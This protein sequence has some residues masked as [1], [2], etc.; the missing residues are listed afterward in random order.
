MSHIYGAVVVVS[1]EFVEKSSS[2]RDVDD[3]ETG[4]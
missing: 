4:I 3:P 1:K 2:T